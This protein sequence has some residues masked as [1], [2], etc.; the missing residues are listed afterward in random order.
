L[1]CI[2]GGDLDGQQP[3]DDL[4]DAVFALDADRDDLIVGRPHATELQGLHHL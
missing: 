1:A 4:L 3:A 2:V